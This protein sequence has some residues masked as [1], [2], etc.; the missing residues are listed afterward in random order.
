LL[1]RTFVWIGAKLF[2]SVVV[3]T[4]DPETDEVLVIHFGVSQ[5]VITESCRELIEDD[6]N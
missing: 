4:P 5:Q 1:L 2:S 3:Y 6:T